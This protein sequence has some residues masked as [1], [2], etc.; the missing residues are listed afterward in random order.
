MGRAR[1]ARRSEVTRRE[2]QNRIGA[3]RRIRAEL[4][5]VPAVPYDFKQFVTGLPDLITETISGELAAHDP[6]EQS[7]AAY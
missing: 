3:Q 5:Q 2:W 7:G 6:L 1:W 4:P